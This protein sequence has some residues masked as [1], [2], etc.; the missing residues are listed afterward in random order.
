MQRTGLA[1]V[2][3]FVLRRRID[4]RLRHWRSEPI[5]VVDSEGSALRVVVLV[6]WTVRDTARAL[7]AVDDHLGY[8]QGA[9]WRR[10]PRGS[11]PNCPPTPSG[12][13]CRPCGTPRPS[14]TP[15]PACSRPSAGRSASRSSP[16]SRRA[17]STTRGGRRDAA[18]ADRGAGRQ[19]PGHRPDRRHR[20]RGRHGHPADHPRTR[21][22]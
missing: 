17:S 22:T 16:P 1:W 7:Y 20:R 2:S 21:R 13:T 14:A 12:V 5:S 4:V 18:A 11:S 8:L 15:S 6:V 10:Q 19:A 3:P 9:R